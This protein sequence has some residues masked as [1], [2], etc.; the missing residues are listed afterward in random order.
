MSFGILRL[1]LGQHSGEMVWRLQ[2]ERS[3]RFEKMPVP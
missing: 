2:A 3:A 1:D